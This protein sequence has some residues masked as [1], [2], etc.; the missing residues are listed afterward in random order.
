LKDAADS[1]VLDYVKV[2]LVKHFSWTMTMTAMALAA[3]GGSQAKVDHPA[4]PAGAPDWVNR[5]N[6]VESRVIYG[7]G[8]VK[9][10]KNP[11]LARD[12]AAN[13]GRAEISKV[14]ETYSASLMKDYSAS[15]SAGDASS[16]E[17]HVEQAV[18]TFS[19]NLMTGTEVTN[20][21]VDPNAQTLFVLV[22]L[23]FDK[24][25]TIAAAKAEMGTS[26]K[27]W[28]DKNGGKVLDDLEGEMKPRP[29][30][31]AE[32]PEAVAGGDDTPPPPPPVAPPAAEP[33]PTVKVGGPQP[34]WT[35][36]QCDRNAYLCGLGSGTSQRAA[37][38][39]ARAE[40]G[41]IFESHVQAVVK[42]FDSAA[43]VISSKT[44][45]AWIEAS[46]VSQMSL[47]STDK[48]VSMSE[49]ADRWADG[50]GTFY[51]LAVIDRAKA[52][53]ALREQIQAKDAEVG[54]NLNAA[55][56]SQD[57]LQRLKALKKAVIAF[58]HRET[59]NSDLRVVR[60]DGRGIPSPYKM[61]DLTALL[62]EAAG[63]LSFGLA[64]AGA[65]AEDL[66]GCLEEALTNRGYQIN[67]N[68]D[69]DEDEIE[70]AGDFDVIIKGQVRAEKRGQ[71]RGAEVVKTTLTLKL[72]NGKTKKILRTITDSDK[73][74]RGGV[75]AAAATSVVKICKRKVP[76]MVQD[77]DRYF[78]R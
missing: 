24:A 61:A 62:E 48:Q 26:M 72:I 9:G 77:I 30:A 40:L 58:V 45:E 37:D 66:R 36:G 15:T 5:G 51:T 23:D 65:A 46:S 59:M 33:G 25:K 78:G 75:R 2:A 56:A 21:W 52:S 14:L 73:G 31:P 19:A 39:D 44:G 47:V 70:I 1:G 22:Q 50:K 12:T 60:T 7:V 6:V 35:K 55:K 34:G 13:R 74:S 20:Q 28:V 17:Q 53:T 64:L 63:N 76:K 11:A 29:P 16:E 18:K 41:R 10:V 32:P 27:D 49:I 54:A 3:C 4:A 43:S 42:S 68:V 71:I 67:A 38:N 69:E 57:K 8:A